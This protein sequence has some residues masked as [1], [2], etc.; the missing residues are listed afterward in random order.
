[1]SQLHELVIWIG[2]GII[3]LAFLI[4]LSFAKKQKPKYFTYIFI[5]IIL[6]LLLSISS[7]FYAY[8]K[9]ILANLKFSFIIQQILLLLQSLMLGL[10]FIEVLRESTFIKKTKYLLFL[11]IISQIIIISFIILKNADIRPS[12]SYNI[13]LPIFCLFYFKFLLINKPMVILA[14]SSIF[15]IV[16]GILISSCFAFPVNSLISFIPRNEQYIN[17][18]GQIFSIANMALTVLYLSIIKSYLCLKHPQNL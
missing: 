7:F 4:A 13:I 17:V 11:S 3:L 16:T 12:I 2:T 1:M 9:T 6:G 8:S 10:F 15:W 14:K 18:R 5:F